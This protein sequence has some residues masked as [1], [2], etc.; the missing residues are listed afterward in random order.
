MGLDDRD[1]M[2][3]RYRKRQG[4]DDGKV[5]WGFGKAARDARAAKVRDAKSV[6]LGSASWIDAKSRVEFTE[7]W[8]S[9]KN[10]GHDYQKGRYRPSP[11]FKA[12]PLQGWILGLSALLTLIPM[13]GAAKQSGWIPDLAAAQSFPESGSV[14]V[15]TSLSTKRLTSWL[16][17]QTSNANAVV[18]LIDPVTREHVLSIYVA[19]DDRVRVPV[20]R[21]TYQMRLIGGQ[22]WHGPIR[23]FGPNTSYETVVK[24]MTF[25]RTA[26]HIIDLR[27]RP[28]GNLHTR[29]NVTRPEPLR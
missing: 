4:L 11:R 28:D 25:E 16:E 14:T 10:R 22:K 6:P 20:P 27:R 3:E 15:A 23:F 12:H 21:G 17:V 26:T 19:G 18:Q 7:P 9:T 24:P 1:Y 5:R 8:F 29:L 13:Y 2:R